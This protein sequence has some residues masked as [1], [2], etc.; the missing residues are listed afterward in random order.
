MADEHS[1]DD[2]DV[3]CMPA[4][5][6]NDSN[7][8]CDDLGDQLDLKVRSQHPASWCRVEPRHNHLQ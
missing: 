8:I 1:R 7:A 5:W 2:P 6:Y 3:P 4:S